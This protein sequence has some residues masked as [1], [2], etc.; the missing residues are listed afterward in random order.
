MIY[1][2][3]FLLV[4]S[5]GGFL[6]FFFNYRK[7]IKYFLED[8]KKVSIEAIVLESLERGIFPLL[9]GSVHALLIDNL[10]LQTIVLAV[11]E[12]SY[13]CVKVFNIQSSTP[14]YK[15]KVGMFAIT[16]ILRLG[17]IVTFYQYETQGNPVIINVI[18]HDLIWLY[19]ICWMAELVHDSI[20]FVSEAIEAVKTCSK[21]KAKMET[22]NPN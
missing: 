19:L 12:L 4:F 3:F 1:F 21:G 5:I 13:L 16:S 17:F 22:Q 10:T 15:F 9:F 2:F 11:V 8:T 18:H 6:W 20:A 14:Q 7:L